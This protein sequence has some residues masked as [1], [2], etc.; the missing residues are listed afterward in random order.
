MSK[1]I[2]GKINEPILNLRNAGLAS[3]VERSRGSVK[4]HTVLIV[5]T[6]VEILTGSKIISDSSPRRRAAGSVLCMHTGTALA[7]YN[8][9][10]NIANVREGT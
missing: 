7:V 5:Q 10:E 3:F 1:H 6:R 4:G 2:S 8:E 9:K